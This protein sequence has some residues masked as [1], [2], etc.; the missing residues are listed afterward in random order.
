MQT[1]MRPAL[2]VVCFTLL[3]LAAL[4]QTVRRSPPRNVVVGAISAVD[5]AAATITVAPRTGPPQTF[6]Y[7]DHTRFLTARRLTQPS[8]LK[9]GDV[10]VVRYRKTAVGPPTLY[11]VCDRP[12]WDWLDRIR[13]ETTRVTILAVDS[14]ALKV[15]GGA[16]GSE[17]EYRITEKTLWARAGKDATPSSYKAGD[18][19]FVTP[20]LLPGGAVMAIAVSD[21]AADAARL[22]ER[23]RSTV[24]GTVRSF[25]LATKTLAVLT[26]AGDD[27]RF[28]LDAGVVIRMASK[29]VP[30]SALRPGAPVTVHFRRTLEGDEAAFQITI[31]TKRPARP[32]PP[33]SAGAPAGS[34]SSR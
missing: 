12:S 11:D 32:R 20:R 25:D 3:P 2:S 4:P 23:A 28:S 16:D 21:T 9:Q 14:E 5:P 7:T 13:H 34:R 24:S 26:A 29:P 15:A 10:V 8:A 17:I 19:V 31:Q 22:K 6:R 30:V 33:S 18:V 27:R 1:C